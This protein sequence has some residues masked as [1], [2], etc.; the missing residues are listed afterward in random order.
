MAEEDIPNA[1][2]LFGQVDSTLSRKFEGAG[3]G[4]PLA[5]KL[6]EL[7][8]GELRLESEVGVG[9]VVTLSFPRDRVLPRE[10]P[11]IAV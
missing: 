6:T 10:E 4:L 9:T 2:A 5:R 1:F 11:A 7:H 3:L 8:G